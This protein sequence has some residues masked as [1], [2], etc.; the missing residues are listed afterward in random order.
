VPEVE[1]APERVT[2]LELETEP[3]KELET[4]QLGRRRPGPFEA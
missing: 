1:P 4:E 2:A 3:E